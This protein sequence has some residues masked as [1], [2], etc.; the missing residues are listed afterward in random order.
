MNLFGFE[1]KV[2]FCVNKNEV[3]AYAWH[4][5]EEKAKKHLEKIRTFHNLEGKIIRSDT[6]EEWLYNELQKVVL[7][8]RK[9]ILPQLEYKNKIVYERIIEIPKGRTATYA[10]IARKSGVKYTQMLITLLRNPF[11]I[12][13]PCHR[14]VTQKGTLMGFYPLGIEVKK[15]LLKIE[16]V[17][18]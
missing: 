4:Y 1:V 7:K 8:G 18:S 12:L 17:I 10:E 14:L 13:V 9:F 6:L 5:T 11:Q 3:T 16:G 15:T 2:F